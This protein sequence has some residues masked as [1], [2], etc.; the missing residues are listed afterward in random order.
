MSHWHSAFSKFYRVP[1]LSNE[2]K[3]R[4]NDPSPLFMQNSLFS[5]ACWKPCSKSIHRGSDCIQMKGALPVQGPHHHPL[6]SRRPHPQPSETSGQVNP[7]HGGGRWQ[8]S[9]DGPPFHFPHGAPHQVRGAKNYITE[10]IL[11][12]NLP[13]I[14]LTIVT[15][16][17]MSVLSRL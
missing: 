3:T 2:L 13:S 16:S 6:S 10:F 8:T 12:E 14:F 15:I 7:N 17:R 11:K 9:T 5:F 4:V 1:P